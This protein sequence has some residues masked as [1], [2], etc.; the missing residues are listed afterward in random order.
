MP[1]ANVSTVV[2]DCAWHFELQKRV[3]RARKR[4]TDAEEEV[5]HFEIEIAFDVG[6]GV[7]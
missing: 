1:G 7:T 3:E 4:T 5:G 2:G 6:Q